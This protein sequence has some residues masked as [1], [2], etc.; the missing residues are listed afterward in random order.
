MCAVGSWVKVGMESQIV[1]KPIEILA[2]AP[3]TVR[4]AFLR[5]AP[6]QKGKLVFADSSG[7]ANTTLVRPV[8]RERDGLRT[9]I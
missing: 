8:V 1:A 6:K 4:V 2:I 5:G 7:Y 3:T 9:T